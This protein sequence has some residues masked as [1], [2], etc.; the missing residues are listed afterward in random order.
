MPKDPKL[1]ETHEFWNER[2]CHMYGNSNVLLEGVPQAQVLTKTLHIQELPETVQ[3]TV[4]KIKL[5]PEIDQAL[6]NIILD[7]YLFDAE[8]KKLMKRKIPER[9]AF[10]LPRDYGITDARKW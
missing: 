10:N 9:P 6:R 2:K 5:S 3:S 8:Q 1:D 7:S 4:I